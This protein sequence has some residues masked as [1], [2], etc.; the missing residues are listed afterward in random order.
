MLILGDMFTN[1]S[2]I[3]SII[4][5]VFFK[6]KQLFGGLVIFSNH[7]LKLPIYNLS[8]LI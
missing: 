2:F 4:D 3:F 6:R 7:K 8:Y 1:I 5:D